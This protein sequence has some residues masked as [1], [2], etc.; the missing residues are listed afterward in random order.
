MLSIT[1][2]LTQIVAT[3]RAVI[4]ICAQVQ[5]RR[6]PAPP[7]LDAGPL[8]I[9]LWNRVGRAA[10]LVA[11]LHALWQ[12]GILHRP[13]PSRAGRPSTPPAV[14]PAIPPL[15][16]PRRRAWLIALGGHHAAISGSQLQHF[17]QRPDAAEFL[18]AVPRAGRHL[19]PICRM[20]G[21]D[22]PPCLQLPPRAP[23][24]P[25]KPRPRNPHSLRSVPSP[26]DPPMPR[27]VLAAARA[28]RK[29]PA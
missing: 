7:A 20:L 9:L 27:Y 6:A 18:A 13:R 5:A 2:H 29:K 21:V 16:I 4:G 11:R 12:Q 10:R 17:L 22:L 8:F 24:A 19:R 23:R 3:L 14:P 15:R 26:N 1:D 28:W 25:R